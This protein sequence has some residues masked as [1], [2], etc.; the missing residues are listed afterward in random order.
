M[1]PA[2]RWLIGAMVVMGLLGVFTLYG[3]PD[4]LFQTAN[5]LWACF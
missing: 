2:V 5:Q 1:K 4:F 3:Q